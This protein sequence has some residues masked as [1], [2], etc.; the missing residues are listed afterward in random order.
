M[1]DA[2][3][4]PL[5][6]ILFY[7]ALLCLSSPL[8]FAQTPPFRQCPHVRTANS[9][10][11]LIVIN[12]NNTVSVYA[13]SSI[14]PY[15]NSEDTLTGVLNNSSRTIA[16]LPLKSTT[17]IFGFDGDGICDSSI[18]PHPAGCP[19]GSTGYEGPGVAFSN[20]SSDKTSG[21]VSFN[22]GIPPGGSAYFGLEEALTAAQGTVPLNTPCPAS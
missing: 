13:D 11:V 10:G 20:I 15:E 17:D 8:A 19:F 3:R 14:P 22:P 1:K 12:A 5:V 2:S 7:S 6:F 9:C 4:S 18:T 16:S 21:T